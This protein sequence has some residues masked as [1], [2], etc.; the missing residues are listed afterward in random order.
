MQSFP[1]ICPDCQR[2][3][4]FI[5]APHCVR[6]GR[7]APGMTAGEPLCGNCDAGRFHFDRAYACF[8]YEGGVKKLLQVY[9][10]AGRSSLGEYFSDSLCTFVDTHLGTETLDAAAAV[11]LDA[12]KKRERG[13]NQS[14]LLS[15]TLA[16]RFGLAES[17]RGLARKR[18]GQPQSSLSKTARKDNVEGLFAA[19][20]SRFHSKRVLLVDDILTTGHTASECA[21][22]LKEA[23]ARSVTVLALARGI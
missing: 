10:F 18:S 23:G 13:F 15:R 7:T 12:S 6:C 9:K 20:E 1:G 5:P 11:P 14:E 3:I 2:R 8:F 21:R 22:A 19:Q 16:S 17:S 4:R